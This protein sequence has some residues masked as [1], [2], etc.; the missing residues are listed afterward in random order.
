MNRFGEGPAGKG[1]APDVDGC[2]LCRVWSVYLQGMARE[3]GGRPMTEF[4]REKTHAFL[5]AGFWVG[6][7]KG[8]L[9][10]CETHTAHQ[11]ILDT[12]NADTEPPKE[13]DPS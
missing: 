7:H 8:D 3:N 4:D 9:T 2:P 5:E 1:V 10:L 6:M 12:M 11:A 13:N